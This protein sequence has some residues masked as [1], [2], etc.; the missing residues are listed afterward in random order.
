MEAHQMK[1]RSEI[2]QIRV[3]DLTREICDGTESFPGDR[4]GIEIEHLATMKTD[5]HNLSRITR[6][7][8]HCGTHI[9]SPLHFV[10]GGGDVASIPL[11]IVP[12][13][14][15]STREKR[16]GMRVFQDA[17]SLAGRAVL[18][19]TGWCSRVGSPD[20]YK[21]FPYLTR[22]S[23][24]FLANSGARIVGLDSPSPD[25]SD[26]V[27]FPAHRILLAEGVQIVESLINLDQ[28]YATA[29]TPF[30]AAFPLRIEG[31]EASPVRAVGLVFQSGEGEPCRGEISRKDRM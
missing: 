13:V 31:L 27:D 2:L 6:L 18:I 4:V 1:K 15:I 16:I 12:A 19:H 5:G 23:A 7:D 9:D 14:V 24:S 25:P 29:G 20:F 3:I 22:E 28:L 11:D 17:G 30:F 21:K 10:D 8:C 26:S